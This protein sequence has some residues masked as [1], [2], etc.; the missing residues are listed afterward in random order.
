MASHYPY[1]GMLLL[2]LSSKLSLSLQHSRSYFLRKTFWS[3][4]YVFCTQYPAIPS[5]QCL[6]LSHQILTGPWKP[7]KGTS[8]SNS[9]APSLVSGTYRQLRN[10]TDDGL[11][12]IY[13]RKQKDP[14]DV[15]R[16][17]IWLDRSRSQTQIKYLLSSPF[18]LRPATASVLWNP[19][20]TNQ[21]LKDLRTH[22]EMLQRQTEKM[23]NLG[24][25]YP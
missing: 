12:E 15:K 4:V 3:Q 7:W 5:L 8:N 9:V 23:Y 24:A 17:N 13:R 16:G 2:S 1:P 11:T 19:A 22:T 6:L 20:L 14:C 10:L 18:V 21:L 25:T